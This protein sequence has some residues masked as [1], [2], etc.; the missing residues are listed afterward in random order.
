MRNDI[1]L[2]EMGAKIKKARK[3]NKITL[4]KMSELCGIDMSNIWFLEKGKRN[5]HILTLK[6]IAEVL[7]MDVKDFI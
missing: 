2:K 5:A 1:Y 7:K 4:E 6:S 3:A